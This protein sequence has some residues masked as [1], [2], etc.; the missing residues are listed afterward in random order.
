LPSPST[1]L[2]E[3]EMTARKILAGL[4]ITFAL[5]AAGCADMLRATADTSGDPAG[6]ANSGTGS[7]S[8]GGAIPPGSNPGSGL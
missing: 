5:T 7:V 2:K 6:S 1:Y 3:M 8:V 4:A